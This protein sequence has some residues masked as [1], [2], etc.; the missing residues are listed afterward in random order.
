MLVN[1]RNGFNCV[2]VF[3]LWYVCIVGAVLLIEVVIIL[4][5]FLIGLNWLLIRNIYKEDRRYCNVDCGFIYLL[6]LLNK[7]IEYL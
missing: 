2:L 5:V 6:E 1:R 3:G 7:L 4:E